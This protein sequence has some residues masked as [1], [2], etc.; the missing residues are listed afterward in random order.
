M[1]KKVKIFSLFSIVTLATGIVVVSNYIYKDRAFISS[2]I[3]SVKAATV[4]RN[5]QYDKI[6]VI[7]DSWVAGNNLDD[8]IQ[9]SFKDK[10]IE[11]ISSGHSGAKSK[12]ILQ[13]LLSTDT[14]DVNSAHSILVDKNI[15]YIV[16]IAGVNDSIGHIG[17]DFYTHHMSEIIKTINSHNKIPLIVEV[18]EFG[19]EEPEPFKSHL[20]HYLYKM[21]FDRNKTDVIK[22][23]RESLIKKL[24]TT[25]LIYKIIPFDPVVSNFAKQ[26]MLFS[27][28]SHLN[29]EGNKMLGNH[30]GNY[31]TKL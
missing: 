26:R 14:S 9:E 7:G 12:Q 20:K 4:E 3:N 1:N 27:N 5:P 22:P 18:P 29:E 13:N 24:A 31:I 11:I 30:I 15:K 10:N 21:M 17:S 28:P 6:G 25:D 8:F 19:I 2:N 16:V 23:Y